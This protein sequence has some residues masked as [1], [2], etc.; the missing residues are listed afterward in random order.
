[1]AIIQAMAGTTITA[2]GDLPPAVTGMTYT[3]NGDSG[4]HN[5]SY[6]NTGGPLTVVTQYTAP[7]Y[8]S[9]G[10]IGT[11]ISYLAPCFD[12]APQTPQTEIDMF[13][14][15]FTGPGGTITVPVVITLIPF[16]S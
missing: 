2:L 4:L 13:S 7:L 8:G 11:V 6:T 9:I 14:L 15:H 12:P 5:L 16:Y 10:I 1:M 3:L